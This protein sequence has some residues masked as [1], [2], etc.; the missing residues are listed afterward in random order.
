MISLVILCL[1][2]QS[3]QIKI[4]EYT[5]LD[6]LIFVTQ[7]FL[8]V[9][10]EEAKTFY[11]ALVTTLHIMAKPIYCERLS[12]LVDYLIHRKISP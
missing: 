10:Y 4:T 9:L 7:M 12:S 1:F 11:K 5:P 2:E 6:S 8:K 3:F